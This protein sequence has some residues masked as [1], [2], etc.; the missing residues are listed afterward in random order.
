MSSARGRRII[1]NI[2]D[3]VGRRRD[4]EPRDKWPGGFGV[5]R[6]A[7]LRPASHCSGPGPDGSDR[8][9]GPIRSRD[10]RD[11]VPCSAIGCRLIVEG[12]NDAI[13]LTNSTETPSIPETHR[14]LLTAATVTLSTVNDDGTVQSTAIWVHLDSDGQLRTITG[15]RTTEVQEP[16]GPPQPGNAVLD[17][18]V[19]P[20]PHL[21]G[22]S[23]RHAQSGPGPAILRDAPGALRARSGDLL[24][25]R[26]RGTHDRNLPPDPRQGRV[27]ETPADGEECHDKPP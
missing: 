14:D 21:G 8:P 3:P 6:S 26:R 22:P 7:T 4:L 10:P 5:R 17:L 19:E 13:H 15:A 27:A 18:T 25:A 24:R 11:D 20:V 23:D 1:L 9:G 16:V 2:R 12:M